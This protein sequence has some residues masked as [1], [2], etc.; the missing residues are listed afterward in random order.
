[1]NIDSTFKPSNV[2][3]IIS[4]TFAIFNEMKS[5]L[6]YATCLEKVL[7]KY[8]LWPY[9]KVKKFKHNDNIVL[10]HN[11]YNFTDIDVEY[12]KLYDE[13]RSL[14]LDFKLTTNNIVVSYANSIP[15]R[16]TMDNYIRIQNPN[17]TFKEAYDGTMITCYNYENKWYFGTSSCPDVNDSKFNNPLKS[18]G[19]MLDEFLMNVYRD[20]FTEEEIIMNDEEFIS[21]KLR[22]LFTCN[23]NPETAY[24][25]VLLHHENKRIIDYSN[26]L[27]ENYKVLI[28]INSKNRQTLEEIDISNKPLEGNGVIYPKVFKDINEA[29]M[30]VT[31]YPN[32][33]GFIIRDVSENGIKLY[34]ISPDYI[35]YKEDTNPMNPNLWHNI[36]I[37]YMK[38]RKDFKICD[39]INTYANDIVLPIDDKNKPIDPTYLIHTMICTLKDVLYKLYIATTTYNPKTNRFKMNKELDQQFPPVIRFHLA[40]LRHRQQK[41][42]TKYILGQKEVYYYL[43]HC[44]NIKNIKILIHLLATNA[45]Y[46]IPERSS[47]C[48]VILDSLL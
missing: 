24:E 4:E 15:S 5:E 44:N 27:G 13:C 23:F 21:Q 31:S 40:Q 32:S 25:F 16:I 28:H 33:Y 42:H 48:L 6:S 29:Y 11:T 38:N 30:F 10:L 18:H 47:M 20:H 35:T 1:M 41:I 3:D 34:K 9:M 22:H 46:D 14:V 7:K 19:Y 8:H 37:V 45:G 12:K 36:L 39:Y 17:H 2:Y 43:C 26:V